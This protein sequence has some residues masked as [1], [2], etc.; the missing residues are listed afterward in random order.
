MST[1]FRLSLLA[2]LGLGLAIPQGPV[3]AERLSDYTVSPS[4]PHGR[5]V[6]SP[7]RQSHDIFPLSFAY[8][9]DARVTGD[10][11]V[12]WLK[13]GEYQIRGTIKASAFQR[14]IIRGT[15]GGPRSA[16]QDVEP[17]TLVV[18]EGKTYHI[19]GLHLHKEE[20]SRRQ[21]FRLVLW[22]VEDG[23][24]KQYPELEEDRNDEDS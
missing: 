5:I 2:L 17:L 13:P 16:R 19:G 7:A 4:E 6:G 20:G 8:I 9:N 23:E 22:K 3:L 12:L 24:D 11:D 21:A 10:R 18:E 14:G 1:L 15:R